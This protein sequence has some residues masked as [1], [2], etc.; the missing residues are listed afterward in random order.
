VSSE[1]TDAVIT[2]IS[3]VAQVV[4]PILAR[5]KIIQIGICSDGDVPDG[6]YNFINYL[7][8]QE[9][10]DAYISEFK[11][12]YGPSSTVGIYS[13]NEAGFER[14]S[15]ELEKRAKEGDIKIAFLERY[16]G[17]ESDFKPMLIRHIKSPPDV[18]MVS[19]GIEILAKQLKVYSTQTPLSS[20]ESF[21][22]AKD[23]TIFKG[24]WYVDAGKVSRK[25]Q[26]KYKTFSKL[27]ITP[28]VSYAYDS[29]FILYRAYLKALV[30]RNN[31]ISQNR[32][33]FSRQVQATKAFTGE[34]GNVYLDSLG[35]FHSEGRVRV[36]GE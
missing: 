1:K 8:A 36:V 19:P 25:F 2:I 32:E 14:I 28:R 35:V 27:E 13:Q 5:A 20:I 23:Q 16:N 29:V 18:L 10:V 26:D 24:A 21:G 12:R 11:K 17:E 3:G 4:K 6:K 34:S 33:E 7:T 31:S 30:A 22:L 9:G 15:K